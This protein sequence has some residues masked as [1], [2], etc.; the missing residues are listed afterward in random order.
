MTIQHKRR[1]DTI[2]E[3]HFDIIYMK[4]QNTSV[5]P[6]QVH[7]VSLTE[8]SIIVVILTVLNSLCHITS[9]WVLKSQDEKIGQRKK[10]R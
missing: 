10:P 3:V 7:G 1:V 2:L 6:N 9:E 4:M 8:N 5:I